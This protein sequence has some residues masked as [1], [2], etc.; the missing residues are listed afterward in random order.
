MKIKHILVTLL[1]LAGIQFTANAQL[2][3][4]AGIAYGTEGSDLGL[5][6]RGVYTITDPWRAAADY[7]YY[8]DG[9]EDLSIWELNFNGH[10]VFINDEKKT[11]YAL[12]GL[13][14]IKA[15]Y[16]SASGLADNSDTG[17]NLGG[18]IEIPL[19]RVEIYAEAR[20]TLGGSD[21][22]LLCGGVQ[23]PIGGN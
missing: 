18:G 22:L 10:Y 17:L 4:G 12:A 14:I 3:L 15:N 23:I 19:S 8:F 1:F 2:K 13:N 5:Q 16:D 20:F 7:I 9:V 6:F 11:L 21:Q